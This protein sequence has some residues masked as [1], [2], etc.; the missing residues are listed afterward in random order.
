[1]KQILAILAMI[2]LAGCSATH[3][4]FIQSAAELRNSSEEET[5]NSANEPAYTFNQ[6]GRINLYQD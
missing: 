2:V 5:S 4:T 6:E 3:D 1:M